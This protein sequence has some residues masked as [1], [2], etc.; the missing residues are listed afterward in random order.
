MLT[1]RLPTEMENRLNFLSN[2]TKRTKSFYAKKALEMYL[3]DLEDTFVALERIT[4]GDLEISPSSKVLE[5]LKKRN[6]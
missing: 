1:L 5:R 6:V 4:E 3:E 2:S